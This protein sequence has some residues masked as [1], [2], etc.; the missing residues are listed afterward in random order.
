MLLGYSCHMFQSRLGWWLIPHHP[1]FLFG[2][3]EEDDEGKSLGRARE[4]LTGISVARCH[5]AERESLPVPR[6]PCSVSRLC[7][8][9]GLLPWR[10]GCLQCSALAG[11]ALTWVPGSIYNVGA[12]ALCDAHALRNLGLAAVRVVTLNRG[13]AEKRRF[14]L[15]SHRN[16]SGMATVS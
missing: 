8:G 4:R 11:D 3:A 7:F 14:T 10:R 15:R 6:R 13:G 1:P 2:T 9:G 5:S 16:H 12:A